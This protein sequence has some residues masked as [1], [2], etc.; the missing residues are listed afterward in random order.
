MTLG[1]GGTQISRGRY[2]LL[3]S[4]SSD[5]RQRPR[6]RRYAVTAVVLDVQRRELQR[7]PRR[8]DDSAGVPRWSWNDRSA[9]PCGTQRKRTESHSHVLYHFFHEPKYTT[10]G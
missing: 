1:D 5:K 3:L 10:R 9:E 2:L 4:T 8:G 6:W 7:R